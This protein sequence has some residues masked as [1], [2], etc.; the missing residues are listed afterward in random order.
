MLRTAPVHLLLAAVTVT[1]LASPPARARTAPGAA[2]QAIP[3]HPLQTIRPGRVHVAESDEVVLK[4]GLASL[5]VPS[6]LEFYPRTRLVKMNPQFEQTTTLGLIGPPD[7]ALDDEDA[8]WIAVDT[9]ADGHVSM[10]ALPS[11]EEMI[12]RIRNA[13]AAESKQRVQAGGEPIQFIDWAQPPRLNESSHTLTWGEEIK[14]GQAPGYRAFFFAHVFGRSETVVLFAEA[15]A[16]QQSRVQ[17]AMD[18]VVANITFADGATYAEHR[19]DEGNMASFDPADAVAGL[20]DEDAAALVADL[21]FRKGTVQLGD[22]LATMD[23]PESYRYLDPD[24]ARSVIVDAWG[25]PPE[26]G[27]DVLGMIFPTGMDPYSEGGWGVVITFQDIG[28][29]DD[30]DAKS[31]DYEAMLEEL[32]EGSAKANKERE[33]RGYPST[34]LVGWARPPSYDA[35]GHA[36]IWARELRFSDIPD[37]T[38]NYDLRLLGRKG[39]LSLNAVA[40]MEEVSSVQAGMQAI[41]KFTRFAE[42]HRYEDFTPGVDEAS[43]VGLAALVLGGTVVA[44]KSGLFKG[45]LVA[46]LAAKKLLFVA[47]AALFVA[48]QRWLGRRKPGAVGEESPVIAAPDEK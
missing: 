33:K 5:L 31:V 37:T 21:T 13:T 38:L 34:E 18:A 19:A 40:T 17:T 1:V 12:D 35:A 23:V 43:E 27:D 11:P 2:S 9:R 15:A 36:L 47:V 32:K 29:I 3:A 20:G 24:D 10:T 4:E 48:L 26:M 25:N 7:Q 28:H 30:A 8:W 22:D 6:G 16:D 45:L 41:M 46:L 39:V 44:A 14:I 42:G